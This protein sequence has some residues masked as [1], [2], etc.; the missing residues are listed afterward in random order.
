[1][2][3]VIFIARAPAIASVVTRIKLITAGEA[4]HHG[5]GEPA[6][7]SWGV[8]IAVSAHDLF[9]HHRAHLWECISSSTTHQFEPKQGARGKSRTARRFCGQKATKASAPTSTARSS[10]RK[11]G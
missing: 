8:H 3:I 10:M 4:G 5:A 11:R 2:S 6:D 1:M 9:A 7:D